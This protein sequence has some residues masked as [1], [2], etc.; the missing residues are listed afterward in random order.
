M[1]EDRHGLC[2]AGESGAP[3]AA[4][5]WHLDEMFVT[6]RCK[7]YLLWRAVDEHGAEFE[8]LL[9]KRCDKTAVKHFFKR[10]LRSNPVPPKIVRCIPNT[11]ISR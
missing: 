2:P 3:E 11:W 9:Q 10:A 1:R 8:I 6:P 4:S 7:P 5:T